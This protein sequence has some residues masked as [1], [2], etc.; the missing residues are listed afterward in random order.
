MWSYLLTLFFSCFLAATIV[1]FSSEVI[2]GSTLM[3]SGIDA[4]L[5]VLVAGIGNTLGGLTG[6]WLGHLGKW[7]WLQKYF[8][9]TPEK[10]ENYRQTCQT[11]GHWL[12]LLCWLP[13]IGDLIC[14]AL[15]FFRTRLLPVS[16][17][18]FIGKTLRYL[19]VAWV[20]LEFNAQG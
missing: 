13:F 16:I 2:F 12:A 17:L 18:M 11:Y 19:I 6:Y 1:P 5:L 14:V 8:R 10:V 9:L 7:S 4:W 3:L 15:G 20:L